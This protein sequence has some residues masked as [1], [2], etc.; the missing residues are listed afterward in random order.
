MEAKQKALW[1]SEDLK[2]GLASLMK[3]GPGL[4]RFVGR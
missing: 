1:S 2:I 4:A 3:N